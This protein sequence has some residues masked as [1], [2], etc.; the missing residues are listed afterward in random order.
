[1]K[2]RRAVI[3][4]ADSM[5]C[6]AMPDADRYGDEGCDT[7][8][9]LARAVGGLTVP[10]LQRMGLGNI[11]PIEGI[12]P[13]D[14]PEAFYAELPML[15]NGKDT[16]TGHWE[17]CGIITEKAFPTYPDGFPPEIVKAFE[18]GTGRGTLG[19]Y[20]ASGTEIIASLGEEHMK[21][22]KLIIYTSADSVFQVAAHEEV[23]PPDE[24]YRYCEIARRILTGDHPVS[25]VIARPFMGSPGA[26]KRTER[27][28]DFALKPPGQTLLDLLK[29]QSM[30][31]FGV[32]KIEDIFSHQGLTD[33]LH[34][35]NNHDGLVTVEKILRERPGQGIIFANLVDF[36]MLYGHRRNALGYA[37][38]IRDMDAFLPRIV[39]AM[40]DDDAL[41]ITADH[42]CDPTFKGSDHTREH[43]PLLWYSKKL[44]PG[45]HLGTRNSFAD[46]SAT[47]LEL[48]GIPSDL[49]GV[50]FASLLG[51]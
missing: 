27:R 19:N 16:T 12:P 22:G 9:N 36:D 1:M 17:I 43:V 50:S 48:F 37:Q 51:R 38:A 45:K 15:S 3:V 42:G 49:A 33:S 7:L 28:K 40:D 5:G 29:D 23:V 30:Q 13:S 35:G 25:R 44:S 46:I 21:T 26:F 8:G 47:I 31:V 34:T 11:H 2:L 10:N 14:A 39:E 18:K 24:L 4:V 32:G 41:I 20:A 6:G